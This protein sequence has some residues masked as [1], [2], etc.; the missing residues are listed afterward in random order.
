M[1]MATPQPFLIASASAAAIAFFAA[2]LSIWRAIGRAGRC[3]L[4]GHVDLSYA[5][6]DLKRGPRTVFFSVAASAAIS[7]RESGAY[8][9]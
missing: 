4:V 8:G 2:A 7:S 3:D 6:A 1:A 5:A 9:G